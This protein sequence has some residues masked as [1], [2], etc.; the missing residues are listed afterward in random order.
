MFV[1]K[2]YPFRELHTTK[3]QMHRDFSDNF[4]DVS[5]LPVLWPTQLHVHLRHKVRPGK[6][7][8]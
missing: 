1:R 7:E 5:R 3:S 8:V 4:Q 2:L 6:E